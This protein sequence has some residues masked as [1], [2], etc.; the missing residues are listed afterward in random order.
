MFLGQQGMLT[1]YTQLYFNS[2][3]VASHKS[4]DSITAGGAPGR[5][6]IGAAGVQGFFFTLSPPFQL[7]PPVV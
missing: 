4:A 3:R 1:K 7:H 6:G 2:H 5:E